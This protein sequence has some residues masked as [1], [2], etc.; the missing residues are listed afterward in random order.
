MNK[1]GY[2]NFLMSWNTVRLV[3]AEI[4]QFYDGERSFRDYTGVSLDYENGNGYP[5]QGE[6]IS[7]S[8]GKLIL[9]I[10]D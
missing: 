10:N 5:G 8:A 7:S 3:Q 6:Q 2:A 9:S 1:I 4:P